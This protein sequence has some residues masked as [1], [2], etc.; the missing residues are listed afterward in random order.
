[1]LAA[2]SMAEDRDVSLPLSGST[3]WAVTEHAS[4]WDHLHLHAQN[5]SLQ[6][7]LSSSCPKKM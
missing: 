5:H 7:K 4:K 2:G 6:E 3:L 1:M